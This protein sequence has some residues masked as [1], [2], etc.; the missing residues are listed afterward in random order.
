MQFLRFDFNNLFCYRL[1]I[2]GKHI[3][4]TVEL[5]QAKNHLPELIEQ[6]IGGNEV[7][8][9]QEGKPLVKLVAFSKHNRTQRHFGSAKGLIKMAADFEAP[10]ED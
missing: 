7:I 5:K 2:K 4:Q 9:T 6:T 8:I 10:M 3:M 1:T